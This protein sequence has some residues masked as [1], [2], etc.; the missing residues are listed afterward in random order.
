MSAL[1]AVTQACVRRV[2]DCDVHCPVPSVDA[3]APYLPKHWTDY[4]REV[5]F[6]QLVGVNSTYP[7]WSEMLAPAR[8]GSI[9]RVRAD[10]LERA[11]IA[12]LNVYYGLESQQHPYLVQALAT[13]V[14]RWLE[15]EWLAKDD[16]LLASVV[17]APQHANSA[18]EEIRRAAADR[19]F[20]QVLLPARS[21][22]PYGSQRYWPIWEAAA[23]TG[24]TPAIS[25]GGSIGTPPTPNG[26][27]GSLF[28]E[29]AGFQQVFGAHVTSLIANGVFNRFPDLKVVLMESGWTW[30]PGLAW[31]IDS[32]WK[33]VRREVP[34]V[35]LPPSEYIKR[36]VRLTTQPIDAR[37]EPKDLRNAVEQL[38]SDEML[39]FGSD[40][41]REYEPGIELLLA[42]LDTE[43]SERILWRNAAET[44]GLEGRL[45]VLHSHPAGRNLVP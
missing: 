12:I 36:H 32:E 19:R 9:E 1:E 2:V 17:V 43:R 28:E 13:A 39:M 30:L 10:V 33:A 29:Y 37:S 24:L 45:P 44:Y 16:R 41:P 34:W 6:K 4:L 8:G 26:W 7:A 42:Q 3:L 11:D 31:R 22:E 35:S 21:W 40:Y 27:V 23:E 20:V 38:G 25:Y 18:A 5:E 14:N 15:A